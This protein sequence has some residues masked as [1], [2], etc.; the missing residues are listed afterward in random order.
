MEALINFDAE[1]AV[2]GGVLH[3]SS[4]ENALYAIETC[5]ATDFSSRD[6]QTAWRAIQ[7][8]S[9]RGRYADIVTVTE[10]IK[11]KDPQYQISYLG[12]CYKNTPSQANLKAYADIVREYGQLR[13]AASALN[14]GLT[15]LHDRHH[16]PTDRIN[17]VLSELASIG[18]DESD[19]QIINLKDHQ[20]AL[21]QH[22]EEISQ[23][24]GSITGLSTGFENLD[25][26]TGG[27]RNG[28]LVIVA[29][30]PSMGK[31]TLVLNMLERIAITN[32]APQWALFFSLE[33]PAQQILQKVYASISSTP[34]AQILNASIMSDNTGY[35]KIGTA[36]EV[37]Q[38]SKLMID[39]KGGQHL[40]QIQSRA[41]RMAIKQGKGPAV[42]VVDYLQL[43][44]AEGESQT[45]RIGNV[46]AGLKNL[47]KQMNCPVIALSQ[48]NR[49]LT[50]KPTL[51][52]LRDSGSIEQ[53]A[54]IVLF[55]HDEDY[56]GQRDEY[57]LTEII[58]AKNR[59][60]R[61]GSTF[62][63]PELQF[64]RFSDTKR[65]PTPKDDQPAKPLK[66][67]YGP[68]S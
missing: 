44:R 39:D 23:K 24:G 19:Q 66:K 13:Q 7:A 32:K 16:E 29:A 34:L 5:K 2:I 35:A 40:T 1:Q 43:I 28:D 37:M 57:S 51:I 36:M 30:R 52:N 68:A 42:I 10:L 3:D 11:T 49:S 58:F 59:M 48:L 67:L 50:G 38:H 17:M 4:S 12:E 33:M 63:Q 14:K 20:S 62:L 45:I 22:L 6:N 64:S 53:D 65:L 9:G 54:D 15:V 18:A 26:M 31:T 47:A 25:Y 21:L 41:K 61:T 46:S 60:G 56:E 8:L 27:L 55:L